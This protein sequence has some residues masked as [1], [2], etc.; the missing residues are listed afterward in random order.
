MSVASNRRLRRLLICW[1]SSSMACETS[2]P[3]VANRTTLP[4][5]DE[6]TRLEIVDS[7]A[8]MNKGF[9]NPGTLTG[10]CSRLRCAICN[11]DRRFRR[12]D[13][14]FTGQH[15]TGVQLVVQTVNSI[16]E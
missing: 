13:D 5:V 6:I 8:L 3:R 10:G 11:S 4:S 2:E 1:S 15:S 7:E 12:C 9:T 16:M 14:F